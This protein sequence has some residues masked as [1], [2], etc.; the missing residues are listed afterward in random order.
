MEAIATKKTEPIRVPREDD[1]ASF[2][3]MMPET[4][5]L[6]TTSIQR[7]RQTNVATIGRL[8]V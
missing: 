7:S 5:A 6:S 8:D 4:V 2:T 3:E 1:E